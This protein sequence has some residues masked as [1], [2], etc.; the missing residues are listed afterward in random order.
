MD[1]TSKFQTYSDVLSDSMIFIFLFFKKRKIR[2]PSKYLMAPF[3]SRVQPHK[4]TFLGSKYT[5]SYFP[6]YKS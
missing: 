1:E 2:L 5:C 6:D 3:N 4:V